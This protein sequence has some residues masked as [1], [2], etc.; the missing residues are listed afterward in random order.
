MIKPYVP[1]L[2]TKWGNI[3]VT[4]HGVRNTETVE[5]SGKDIHVRIVQ[6]LSWNERCLYR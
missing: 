5:I 3:L 6:T 2:L 1:N 4:L